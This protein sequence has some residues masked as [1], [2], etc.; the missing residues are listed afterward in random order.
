MLTL[1]SMLAEAVVALEA[2]L[3]VRQVVVSLA[4]SMP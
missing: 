1:T 2:V 4:A 3:L